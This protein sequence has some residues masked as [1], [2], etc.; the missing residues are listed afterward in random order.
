MTRTIAPVPETGIPA[1]EESIMN[2]IVYIV[3]AIVIVLVI[4]SVLGL[5]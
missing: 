1:A 3:G 4:L 5:R 2:N